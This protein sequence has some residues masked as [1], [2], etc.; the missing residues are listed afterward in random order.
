VA[1]HRDPATV[2]ARA[3]SHPLRVTILMKMNTPRR[4]MSPSGFSDET[5]EALGNCSYH[6]RQLDDFGLI[7][8][9]ETKQVR[10]ATEHF[11]E[12]TK[13]A[14]AWTRA[15][16]KMPDALKQ[17]LATTALVGAVESIGGAVDA[18][19]FDAR[20]DAHL[21]FDATVV[22]LPGWLRMVEILNSA[23]LKLCK[24]EEEVRE[25]LTDNP[26]AET[27]VGSYLMS[28]WEA[29]TPDALPPEE[30]TRTGKLPTLAQLSC[31]PRAQLVRILDAALEGLRA[32][33][34]DT[35]T[36]DYEVMV[37]EVKR[38]LGEAG[39]APA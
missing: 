37:G 13:R 30:P 33:P 19:T 20:P 2:I 16:G 27:W 17:N 29:A 1:E 35:F 5:G 28:C 3:L 7:E 34:P 9:V 10:G 36:E 39:E 6:F 22:D 11:Y 4:R 31:F 23:L 21:S 26:D 15:Y 24:V 12:P 18:G 38:L 8:L 25:R 14:M 32:Q